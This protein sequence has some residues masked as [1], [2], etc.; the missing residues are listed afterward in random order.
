MQN[1]YLE[2]FDNIFFNIEKHNDIKKII[3]QAGDVF[4]S[5]ITKFGEVECKMAIGNSRNNDYVDTVIILFIRKIMEQLDSIN[6]LYSVGSFETAQ[7]ILRSLFE[8]IVELEFI[9]KEQTSKRAAAYFLEHHYQELDMREIYYN[10]ES[11]YAQSI[12]AKKGKDEF[13]KDCKKIEQKREALERLI[14]SNS[15]FQEIDISRKRKLIS[16]GKQNKNKKIYIQWYEVCSNITSIYG[17]M[18]ETGYKNYYD[19]IY[20]GL[21]FE[22]HG[23][24][25][26][27]GISVNKNELSLKWIRNPENGSTTFDL[28][29]GLSVKALHKIY[30]YLG[31][32]I[33]EMMEFKSYFENYEKKRDYASRALDTIQITS[34]NNST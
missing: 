26:A 33:N 31:Y 20:G 4:D 25:A 23:L 32:G 13:D 6:V 3:K 27:M 1:K 34:E 10:P 28:A 14:K 8:N 21:S 16:K 17:L 12:I 18:K 15:V 22:V 11:K 9:L 24:N 2:V 30:Q 29:C 19:S 7:I 5:V